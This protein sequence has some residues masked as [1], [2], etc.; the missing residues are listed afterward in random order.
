VGSVTRDFKDAAFVMVWG[1]VASLSYREV[2]YHTGVSESDQQ[3]N[4]NKNF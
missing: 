2:F 3:I 1:G 4:N